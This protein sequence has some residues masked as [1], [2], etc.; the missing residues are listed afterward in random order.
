MQKSGLGKTGAREESIFKVGLQKEGL[1]EGTSS[2]AHRF[3]LII[4]ESYLKP[5]SHFP[6]LPRLWTAGKAQVMPGALQLKE[7]QPK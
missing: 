4:P 2:Y 1:K 7:Q 5:H 6:A 3:P